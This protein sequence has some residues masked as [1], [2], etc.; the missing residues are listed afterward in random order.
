M[1][2]DI[3]IRLNSYFGQNGLI[4]HSKLNEYY[5]MALPKFDEIK[6][7]YEIL[8]SNPQYSTLENRL[9]YI[10]SCIYF[11]S[12]TDESYKNIFYYKVIGHLHIK[13]DPINDSF[14]FLIY[15]CI[16]FEENFLV[17]KD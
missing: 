11:L 12:R 15:N 14:L 2:Q 7:I 17:K 8:D 9:C 3:I 4:F 10:S 1:D 6:R 16:D 13:Q 5:K